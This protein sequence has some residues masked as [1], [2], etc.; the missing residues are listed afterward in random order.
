MDVARGRDVSW[1]WLGVG[2]EGCTLDVAGGRDGPWMWLGVGVKGWTLDI[3]G[4]RGGGMD[5]GCGWG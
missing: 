1:L 3:A 5:L 4:G 2:V